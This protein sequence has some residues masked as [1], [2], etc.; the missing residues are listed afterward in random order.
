M[1]RINLLTG[2][3][4]SGGRRLPLS[5]GFSTIIDDEDF[6]WFAAHKWC[7]SYNTAPD[8]QPYAVRVVREGVRKRTIRMHREVMGLDCSDRRVV[9]HLNHDTLD[10]RKRNL[11]VCT[12]RENHENWRRH[13]S[14]YGVG[15]TKEGEYY[16]VRV[17]LE[18]TRHDL[19]RF[20]TEEEARHARR[21]FIENAA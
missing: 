3:L 9:D 13:R 2:R 11:R 21:S 4:L 18:G 1:I 19:G 15:I 10:N 14:P 7:A 20:P 16:R 12:Q 5:K 17:Q 8:P 6:E